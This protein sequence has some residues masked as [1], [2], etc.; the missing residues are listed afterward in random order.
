MNGMKVL[1]GEF[2]VSIAMQTFA[3][4]KNKYLPW[5]AY[6]MQTSMAFSM[7][8]LLEIVVPGMGALLGAGMM[9]ALFVKNPS[10]YTGSSEYGPPLINVG[11]ILGF[12]GV[13][14]SGVATTQPGS[15]IIGG[16]GSGSTGGG[17]TAPPSTGGTITAPPN[18]AVPL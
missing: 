3:A 13:G 8:A 12:G 11:T 16:S 4:V 7:L 9:I 5:P 1:A 2:G 17:S 6:F 18:Y 14:G 10:K 15:F